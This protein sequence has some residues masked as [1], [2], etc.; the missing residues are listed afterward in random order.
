MKSIKQAVELDLEKPGRWLRLSRSVGLGLAVFTCSGLALG[1]GTPADKA[2]AEALFQQGQQLM[3][4]QRL[5]EACEKFRASQQLDSGLGTMLYLADCYEQ[6]GRTAS[7]W[8]MFKEAASVA[9]SRGETNREQIARVRADALKP[10]L[11]YII[12]RSAAPLPADATIE[13]DGGIIPSALL[14]VAIPADPG[15]LDVR[16]NA[17]GFEPV[18]VS[19]QVPEATTQPVEITLPALNPLATAEDASNVSP[20]Q[21]AAS[22]STDARQQLPVPKPGLSTEETAGLVLGGVGLVAVGLATVFTVIG[23]STHDESLRD[24]SAS[25]PNSCG[26][27]GTQLREEALDELGL[28]TLFGVIGTAA[29]GTGVALYV[30]FPDDQ[31]GTHARVG[32]SYSGAW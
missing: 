26:P 13:R 9:A 6:S 16:V 14:G 1:Q 11:S 22:L 31:P 28:A 7:A 21:P 30:A 20:S 23:S 10:R 8:A 18:T 12:I 3:D 17:P 32:L 29:L 19:S 5:D 27:K 24:C 15:N 4:E 2:A 25:D